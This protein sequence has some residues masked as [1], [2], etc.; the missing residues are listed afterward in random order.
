M[1]NPIFTNISRKL[2]TIG[3]K[4]FHGPISHKILLTVTKI[5]YV[6][7]VWRMTLVTCC[8]RVDGDCCDQN[9]RFYWPL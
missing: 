2:K 4:S 8:R 9:S 6:T 5:S 7:A 1:K 3:L